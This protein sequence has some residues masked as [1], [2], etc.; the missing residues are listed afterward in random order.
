[1]HSNWSI[2]IDDAACNAINIQFRQSVDTDDCNVLFNFIPLL[3][4]HFACV[5]TWDIVA[6]AAVI[7]VIINSDDRVAWLFGST[8]FTCI[9]GNADLLGGEDVH[10]PSRTYQQSKACRHIPR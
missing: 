10:S 4:F 8:F 6:L 2:D 1:M 9:A 3:S 5:V 7:T